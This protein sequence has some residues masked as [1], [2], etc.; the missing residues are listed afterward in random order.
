MGVG[1]IGVYLEYL[2]VMLG[3]YPFSSFRLPQNL[4]GTNLRSLYPSP[5]LSLFT[6]LKPPA[7]EVLLKAVTV[8]SGIFQPNELFYIF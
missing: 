8:S 1:V 2:I 6:R 7:F 5:L 4:H 3:F